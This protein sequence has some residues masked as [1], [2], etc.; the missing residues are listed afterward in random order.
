MD[1]NPFQ[2]SEKV[3]FCTSIQAY[4]QVGY[5]M[6]RPKNIAHTIVQS[7]KAP[8][9]SKL[10]ASAIVLHTHK[11]QAYFEELEYLVTALVP[12]ETACYTDQCD[13][14]TATYLGKLAG[15]DKSDSGLDLAG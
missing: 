11:L 1:R 2:E 4:I 14:R 7:G 3:E 13:S 9:Q 12:S 10:P 8:S 5:R 6:P 15:E